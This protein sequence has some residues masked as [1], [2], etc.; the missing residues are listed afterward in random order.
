MKK[1]CDNSFW[2]QQ[3]FDD[4]NPV[5]S[6]WLGATQLSE[7]PQLVVLGNYVA[8]GPNRE[9]GL[10][11]AGMFGTVLAGA[12]GS[13]EASRSRHVLAVGVGH[14]MAAV[15]ILTGDG[16]DGVETSPQQYA[17]NDQEQDAAG[18]PDTHGELPPGPV[19]SF[20]A[21]TQSAEHLALVAHRIGCLTCHA[22]EVGSLGEEVGQVRAGL[23]D[24]DA[25]LMH[26]T[27]ALVAHEQAVPVW[28]VHDAV[29]G[30]QAAGGRWPAH[31]G[32]GGRDVVH[33]NPHD[34]RLFL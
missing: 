33:L 17:G 7:C 29:E 3:C 2:A 25:F 23:T 31:S 24:R 14:N 30:V 34:A 21:V 20:A 26:E 6:Y 10:H 32:R 8:S 15:C 11:D 16:A 28:V 4:L 22:Q 13:V 9:G 1:L 27:L 12:S 18:Q 5:E 19:V